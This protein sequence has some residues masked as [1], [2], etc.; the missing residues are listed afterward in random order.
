MKT[1][2]AILAL[3]LMSMSNY[4][5]TFTPGTFTFNFKDQ[6]SGGTSNAIVVWIR[7]TGMNGSIGFRKTIALDVPVS[8]WSTYFPNWSACGA[9]KAIG[10][11]AGTTTYTTFGTK[12]FTWDGK[13]YT[14]AIVPDYSYDV[15]IENGDGF[16]GPGYLY[17]SFKK[18][19][20]DSAYTYGG[21]S[22]G[23]PTYISNVNWTWNTL[24][25]GINELSNPATLIYP[26][27]SNGSFNI[28]AHGEVNVI[29]CLGQIVYHSIV[30]GRETIS[31]DKPGMYIVQ[32]NDGKTITNARL[33]NQ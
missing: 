1:K 2:I 18:T 17:F 7:E 30:N 10:F 9:N 22:F 15:C 23:G 12:S 5:Q 6:Y 11:N 19:T 20:T 33:I 13:D 27:P 26:N 8:E 31:I 16:G 32:V 24:T 21:Q 29:N 4:A 25:T 28:E 14:G 3:F